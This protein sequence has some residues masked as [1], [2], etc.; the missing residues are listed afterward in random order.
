MEISRAVEILGENPWVVEMENC[1]LGGLQILVKYQSDLDKEICF[2]HDLIYV[3][4]FDKFVESMA[5]EDVAEMGKLG[6]SYDGDNN[7][8]T[9]F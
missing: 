3:G 9:H 5:E 1:V 8:W 6:W 2:E 7:G 4:H